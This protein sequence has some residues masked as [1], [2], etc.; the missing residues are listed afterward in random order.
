MARRGWLQYYHKQSD[1]EHATEIALSA[2]DTKIHLDSKG[3]KGQNLLVLTTPAREYVFK[4][5]ATEEGKSEAFK[6]LQGLREAMTAPPPPQPTPVHTS[7]PLPPPQQR[8]YNPQQ[9]YQQ[10]Q[11]QPQPQYGAP[12]YQPQYPPQYQPQYPPQY[13]PQ[14]QYAGGN[15]YWQPGMDG[16]DGQPHVGQ[17]ALRG[18]GGEEGTGTNSTSS[19]V[20]FVNWN[21]NGQA[22]PPS[23]CIDPGRR[24]SGMMVDGN[25]SPSQAALGMGPGKGPGFPGGGPNGEGPVRMAP[26][27]WRPQLEAGG[28]NSMAAF[29]DGLDP[30]QSLDL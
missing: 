24:E 14:Q 5:P 27:G 17:G 25:I 2:D 11:Y 28:F 7:P 29:D 13:Q 12:Q 22:A 16:A 1:K 19:T 4:F 20:E 23:M 18:W 8:P 26:Q 21:H 6:W 10:P 15:G 30:D 9:Q 3:G